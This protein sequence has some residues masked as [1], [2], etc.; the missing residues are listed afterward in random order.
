M[1]LWPT[2][3][4]QKHIFWY[5]LKCVGDAFSGPWVI[6]GDCNNYLDSKDKIRGRF[7]ASTRSN[8][9]RN[10]VDDEVLIDLGFEGGQYTWNNRRARKANIQFALIEGLA[11][12]FF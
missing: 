8:G 3:N 9:F 10:F 2:Q 12:A 1:C 5:N 6:I 11:V 7:L 4:S